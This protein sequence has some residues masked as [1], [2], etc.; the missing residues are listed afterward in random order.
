MCHTSEISVC[1]TSEI[2]VVCWFVLGFVSKVVF[3][4][5]AP[6]TGLSWDLFSRC[7]STGLCWICSFVCVVYW[8]LL[9]FVFKP[10]T[11]NC[12]NRY[13]LRTEKCT[14][15]PV[16]GKFAWPI[17]GLLSVLCKSFLLLKADGF[18]ISHSTARHYGVRVGVK[19]K[20]F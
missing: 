13:I 3:P 18:Q 12:P 8:F 16:N 10:F 19:V 17:T 5:C 7:L 20:G 9:G 4:S 6:S 15:R 2:C 11:T 14:Q 1:H